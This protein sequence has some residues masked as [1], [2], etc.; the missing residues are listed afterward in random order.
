LPINLKQDGA[1]YW[2]RIIEERNFVIPLPDILEMFSA[3]KVDKISF[4][5]KKT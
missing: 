1:S 5:A 3:I 4:L 2:E